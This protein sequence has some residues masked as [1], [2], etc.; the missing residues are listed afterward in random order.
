[1][2]ESRTYIGIKQ[3]QATPMTRGEYNTYRGWTIPADED[4]ADDG[5]LMVDGSGL[6]QWQ[7]K[8]VFDTHHLEIAEKNIVGTRAAQSMV[9][10]IQAVK[11][12]KNALTVQVMLRNGSVL[13]E[14]AYTAVPPTTEEQWN[15]LAEVT[16]QKCMNEVAQNLIFIHRWANNGLAG[17]LEIAPEK[18]L[19][20]NTDLV[21]AAGKPLKL[22]T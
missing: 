1:M 12:N 10:D 5:Y 20:Q 2:R 21:S 17:E 7:P 13:H 11:I 15:L 22:V 9:H 4:P 16:V 3:I 8:G 6:E 14:T 18:T 19:A